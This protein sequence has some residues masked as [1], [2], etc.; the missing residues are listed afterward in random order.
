L[1]GDDARGEVRG[2][3]LAAAQP[4]RFFRVSNLEKPVPD[5]KDPD[6]PSDVPSP[7]YAPGQVPEEF[8]S[9]PPDT[10]NPDDGR[11]RDL[12][13]HIATEGEE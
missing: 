5:P 4:Q 10:G 9:D 1:F 13:G 7:E 12:L 11:P 2:G 8:P 6:L 3:H